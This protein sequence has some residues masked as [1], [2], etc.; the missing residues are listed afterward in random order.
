MLAALRAA[1]N[2]GNFEPLIPWYTQFTRFES[3]V[4]GGRST[5]L[6]ADAIHL[7]WAEAAGGTGEVTACDVAEAEGGY[8][9][10][11]QR[12][13]AEPIRRRHT[14][15]L[16][17][18][19]RVAWHILY[20]ARPRRP[21]LLP[22]L[23]GVRL[24]TQL[25]HE[26]EHSGWS[27]SRLYQTRLAT[28]ESVVVK[29]LAPDQD[30]MMRATRDP[31]REA[32]LAV[33]DIYQQLP[34][35]LRATVLTAQPVPDGWI[36]VMRDVSPAHRALGD[37]MGRPQLATA[38]QALHDLHQAFRG[39]PAL[40]YLCTIG[41]RIRL[42][43]P[44]RPLIERHGCDTLP[45]T[46]IPMWETWADRG[47][48]D[49]VAAVLRVVADP[50]PLLAEIAAQTEFTLLHG[51]YQVSNLALD[52]SG[53]IALDWGL[54]CF[55]PPEL[56]FVWFLSNTAWNG[57]EEREH[58]ISTWSQITRTPADS[59]ALDLA[60][61]FHAAM[62]ELAF[63]TTEPIYQPPGFAVPSPATAAWWSRRVRA[64]LDRLALA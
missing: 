56:D 62:G 9:I 59:R 7:E 43:S 5:V 29:H 10:D 28:G 61:V 37:T 25:V 12:D 31:G 16:A 35:A 57:D 17:P 60:V 33:G 14:I 63:L 47:E 38:L 51:D 39:K 52:S 27:G 20:P 22:P 64:A 18:D 55:G 30:W 34:D 54:A 42:F 50:S 19:G 15:H 26:W 44:L 23:R 49:V 13:T 8:N 45:K 48:R 53:M 32:L 24:A 21:A 40:D 3:Y 41:D 6:G 46:F 36:I 1:L 2:D 58:L 11:I 4:S